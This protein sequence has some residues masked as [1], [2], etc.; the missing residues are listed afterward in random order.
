MHQIPTF[1]HL[2]KTG[3]TSLIHALRQNYPFGHCDIIPRD[4]NANLVDAEDIRRAALVYPKLR[5]LAGHSIRPFRTFGDFDDRLAYYTIIRNGT[6]RYI[7]EYFHDSL[8]RGFDA[9][10]DA[11]ARYEERW[12]YQT[13]SLAGKE[14]LDEA[15]RILTDR[16][17]VVGELGDYQGFVRA[18]R[19]LFRRRRFTA[20]VEHLNRAGLPKGALRG[21]PALQVETLSEE[22]R[23]L[24][25]ERNA[26]D[27]ELHR[28]VRDELIPA[29]KKE[30][31]SAEQASAPHNHGSSM[32]RRIR[33]SASL[34][35]R[36]C[37][38]KPA[39]GYGPGAWH[40]LPVN[41]VN[42]R[43]YRLQIGRELP[44]D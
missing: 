39:C 36:N 15:K 13:R 11:W 12:N 31:A 32:S 33:M 37:I 9:G 34:M 21:N 44:K 25:A 43:D 24:A 29:R 22:Q 18:V 14:D 40:A 4:R 3:G 8:R 2:E 26:L 20:N 7:S 30:L 28:Y 42:V 6:D 17:A 41:A 5:S 27:N 1:V 35:M 10:F 23:D 16:F 38:Y 19:T